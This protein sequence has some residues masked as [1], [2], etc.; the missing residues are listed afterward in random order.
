MELVPTKDSPSVAGVAWWIEHWPIN[1]KVTGS[2]PSQG[3][4]LGCGLGPQLGAFCKRQSVDVSH[5]NVSLLVSLP[6][7][8]KN[9]Q[10][11]IF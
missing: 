8:S 2:I 6:S 11:K 9:K 1:Q 7:P 5:I 10:V 3:T 4:C